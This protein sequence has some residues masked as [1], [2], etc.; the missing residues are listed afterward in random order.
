MLAYNVKMKEIDGYRCRGGIQRCVCQ[1][2][3]Q[4]NTFR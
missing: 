3:P 1:Y 4:Y 2:P